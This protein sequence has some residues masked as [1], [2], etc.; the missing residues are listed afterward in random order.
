[1]RKGLTLIEILVV[2]A[3]ILMVVFLIL[4]ALGLNRQKNTF[5]AE[6]VRKYEVT[7][8]DSTTTNNQTFN[9]VTTKRLV[10]LRRPGSG[11]VE[12]CENVDDAFAGKNNSG[13]IHANL[14]EGNFY[15]ITTIGSRNETMSWYPNIIEIQKV[16]NPT[17]KAVPAEAPA[18]Q[19]Q[20]QPKMPQ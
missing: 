5:V 10:D 13:T 1:M 4:P 9:T 3:I 7:Q 12:T 8:N 2:I 14:L 20:P 11:F 16:I 18:P 17:Y 15:Q 6:V 19:P